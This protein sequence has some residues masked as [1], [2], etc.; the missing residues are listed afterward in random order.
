V[1]E[2][3]GLFYFDTTHWPCGLQQQFISIMEKS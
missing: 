1:D 2:K 3:K